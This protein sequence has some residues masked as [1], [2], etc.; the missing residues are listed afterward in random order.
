M[1]ADKNIQSRSVVISSC[2]YV[3][4]PSWLQV[5]W[6][7]LSRLADFDR[8]FLLPSPSGNLAGCLQIELRYDTGFAMM[9]KL[10][11]AIPLSGDVKNQPAIAHFWTPHSGRAFMPSST[12]V[13]GF[14]EEERNF[15]GGV[16]TIQKH[17]RDDPLGEAETLIHLDEFMAQKSTPS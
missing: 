6:K 16:Q 15:L 17:D 2:C 11:A 9:N 7:L 13:L 3:R 8:D 12:V 14:S 5:G 4:E 10:L 1:G